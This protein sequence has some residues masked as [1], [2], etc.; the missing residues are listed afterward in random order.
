[1]RYFLAGG[2]YCIGVLVLADLRRTFIYIRNERRA[3]RQRV[4]HKLS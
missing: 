3:Q 1:M 4:P 2:L